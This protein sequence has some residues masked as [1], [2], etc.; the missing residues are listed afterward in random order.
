MRGALLFLEVL[1]LLFAVLAVTP[2]VLLWAVTFH[3]FY[4]LVLPTVIG[5]I[6]GLIRDIEERAR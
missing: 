1:L 4:P 5:N 3:N 6:R 2:L